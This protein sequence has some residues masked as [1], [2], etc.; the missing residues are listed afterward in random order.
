MALT[1]SAVAVAG[2]LL[3][4]GMTHHHGGDGSDTARVAGFASLA[5]GPLLLFTAARRL[6]L[7]TQVQAHQYRHSLPA[8]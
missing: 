1:A 7:N 8:D 6:A 2:L 3:L 5:L 4:I